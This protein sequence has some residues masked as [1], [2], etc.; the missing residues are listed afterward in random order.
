M[1]GK[2]EE[3]TPIWDMDIKNKGFLVKERKLGC[4]KLNQL[5]LSLSDI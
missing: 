5:K 4:D 3:N 1:E 2:S